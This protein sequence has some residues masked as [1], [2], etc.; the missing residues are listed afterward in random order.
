MEHGEGG[1]CG[2][3]PKDGP[4]CSVRGREGLEE[5][6]GSGFKSHFIQMSWVE[7]SGMLST[8]L[9]LWVHHTTVG[10][11]FTWKTRWLL[12][13]GLCNEVTAGGLQGQ[14]RW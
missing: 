6:S 11:S 12:P 2:S 4:F 7:V 1:G 13:S 8:E 14:V 9:G 10:V 3:S 5:V